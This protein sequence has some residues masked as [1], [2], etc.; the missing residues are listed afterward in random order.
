MSALPTTVSG[1][2]TR[3]YSEASSKPI[4]HML[5]HACRY[6]LANTG[7]GTRVIQGWLSNRSITSTAVR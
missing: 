7:H 1:S 6:A 3:I 5:R 2:A 4:P